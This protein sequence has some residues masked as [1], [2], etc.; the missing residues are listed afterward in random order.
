MTGIDSRVQAQ[1]GPIAPIDSGY[2][3]DGTYQAVTHPY[4]NP[5]WGSKKAYFFRPD[6]AFDTTRPILF[7]AHGYNG[8]DTAYYQH[9]INHAVS[10]GYNFVFVPYPSSGTYTV[11]ERYDIMWSGFEAA[12][13]NYSQYIDTMKT[14][15]IGHSFGGGALPYLTL[16]AWEENN[17]GQQGI[18][19]MP[20]APWYSHAI[21]QSELQNFPEAANLLMQVY[22]HDSTNDHRMA[23][24]I[25][26][27]INIPHQ[28]KTYQL[29]FTDSSDN[30]TLEADHYLP[31]SEATPIYGETDGHDYYAVFRPLDALAD[32]TF[33][34]NDKGYRQVFDNCYTPQTYMGTWPDSTLV[35][36]MYAGDSIPI[37][38]AESYY[39]YQ[40]HNTTFN[41]RPSYCDS[42]TAYPLDTCDTDT[43]TATTIMAQSSSLPT[44]LY[45]NPFSRSAKLT[46]HLPHST[47]LTFTVYNA[48]GEHLQQRHITAQP[49]GRHFLRIE[50]RTLPPG[51]YFYTLQG[52]NTH[53][54]QQGKFIIQ[55]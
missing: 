24:D 8:S 2:G 50:G 1:S 26:Q 47:S 30:Y 19:M 37:I 46:Y 33:T 39:T 42:V 21:S 10:R 25:F 5:A 49:A 22:E 27:Y 18:F 3:A 28:R 36:R 16:K 38:H 34:N 11:K 23:R 4:T 6:T 29:I 52:Q 17:W 45:P 44:Q 41:P 31:T 35:K 53:Y 55:H 7:F 40:C 51:L 54:R 15:F 13:N 20:L 12:V 43:D 14:G 32:Y 9:L 48:Q